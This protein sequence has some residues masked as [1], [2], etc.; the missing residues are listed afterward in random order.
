MTEDRQEWVE[1]RW[2]AP[3][4]RGETQETSSFFLSAALSDELDKKVAP[5]WA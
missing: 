5:E 3:A 1:E 2:G 4:H